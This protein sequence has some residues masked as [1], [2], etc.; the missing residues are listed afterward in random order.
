[1]GASAQNIPLRPRFDGWTPPPSQLTSD[2]TARSTGRKLAEFSTIVGWSIATKVTPPAE[3]RSP[4]KS[5]AW[6]N[7][8]HRGSSKRT[9]RPA[10]RLIAEIAPG[11]LGLSVHAESKPMI[12]SI[13]RPYRVL[14]GAGK[15]GQIGTHHGTKSKALLI[16]EVRFALGLGKSTSTCSS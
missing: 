4:M 2:A 14:K 6:P 7:D 16:E 10:S 15:S 11:A 5:S 12:I 8:M 3:R 9:G 1:M 13:A